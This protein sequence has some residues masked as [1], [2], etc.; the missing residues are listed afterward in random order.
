MVSTVTGWRGAI[1]AMIGWRTPTPSAAHFRDMV[2]LH[3]GPVSTM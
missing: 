3:E 2:Y 1:V